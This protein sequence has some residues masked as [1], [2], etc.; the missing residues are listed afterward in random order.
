[1]GLKN[2]V[3]P[4]SGYD[5]QIIAEMIKHRARSLGIKAREYS[6]IPLSNSVVF[7]FGDTPAITFT[8]SPADYFSGCKQIT[9]RQFLG[10]L[11]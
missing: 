3:A 6:S 1:M 9:L 10:A 2:L 4:I 7:S 8:Y 5:D 11:L